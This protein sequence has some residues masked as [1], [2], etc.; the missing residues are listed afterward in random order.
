MTDPTYLYKIVLPD[1]SLIEQSPA[2]KFDPTPFNVASGF[3]HLSTAT[4]T[5]HTANRFFNSNEAIWVLKIKYS[6][7]ATHVKWEEVTHANDGSRDLFPHL[8]GTF[9]F[10]NVVNVAKLFKS[11]MAHGHFHK[12]GFSKRIIM[13]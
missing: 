9:S 7:I 2:A 8:F 10:A 5:P 6:D 4:Q 1:N 11:R 3:V 13:P 12:L